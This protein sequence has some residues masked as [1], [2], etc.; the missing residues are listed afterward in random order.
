VPGRAGF[1]TALTLITMAFPATALGAAGGTGYAPPPT[2]PSHAGGTTYGAKPPASYPAHPTVAGTRARLIKGIAYAPRLAPVEVQRAIWA[3]N[4]LQHKPYRYGGGHARFNDTGY[5]CSG[6]VS[7]ALHAAGL[8]PRPLASGDFMTWGAAGPGQW[9]TV[10]TNPG[11]A[12]TI[13][14]GLRLDTSPAGDPGGASGPRWR[15]SA[16]SAGGYVARHPV[17]F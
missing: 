6:T 11:H 17:G 2:S 16:R 14:A 13:I 9:I 4:R 1:A 3:A 10:Y 8:L 7:Y 12:Y 15:R 5:D